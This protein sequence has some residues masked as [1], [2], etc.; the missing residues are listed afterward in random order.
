M[1]DLQTEI[2]EYKSYLVLEKRLSANTI[3]AYMRDCQSFLSS[4][5]VPLEQVRLSHIEEYL[6]QIYKDGK[7]GSSQARMLSGIKSFF[8]YL[9]L[10]DKISELPTELAVAPKL[11]RHIP[12][13]LTVG[14]ME[15]L[16]ASV[17]LSHPQGHRNK[18]IIELMYSCGLRVSELITLTLSD[19]FFDDGY[20]RVVGKGDKQRLVPIGESAIAAINLYREQRRAMTID[21]KSQELLFLGRRGKGLTRVM[22]F[23]IIKEHALLAG[24]TKSISPHTL[25]HT[26]ASHL[27]LGGADVRAVQQML[28]HESISTT[29]IYVHINSSQKR[30][31]VEKL[32]EMAD[33]NA[34]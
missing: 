31:S 14:E 17:D 21:T 9:Y 33:D 11:R 15:S 12:S 24:I 19:I 8:T 18:A 6:E 1:I 29:E 10:Y 34:L 28:G 30:A 22:I 5:S 3:E 27:I 23:H 4:L 26:F 7:N 13:Y 2:A 32:F 25:R 20:I 16:I